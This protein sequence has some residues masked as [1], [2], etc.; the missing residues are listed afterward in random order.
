MDTN[1][2]NIHPTISNNKQEQENHPLHIKKK[3]SSADNRQIHPITNIAQNQFNRMSDEIE[4]LTNEEIDLSFKSKSSKT[5]AIRVINPDT[6]HTEKKVKRSR[7]L[8]NVRSNN[9][10]TND[11]NLDAHNR[12]R[13][14][15]ALKSSVSDSKKKKQKDLDNSSSKKP[16]S[17]SRSKSYNQFFDD[18]LEELAKKAKKIKKAKIKKTRHSK[19]SRNLEVKDK[20]I[21][22]LTE[23]F[24]NLIINDQ[25]TKKAKSKRKN[26]SLKRSNSQLY[27]ENR[28]LDQKPE[29]FNRKRYNQKTTRN[30]NHIDNYGFDD[31][32]TLKT[33]WQ[34]K[35]CILTTGSRNYK[36]EIFD[37]DDKELHCLKY[38]RKKGTILSAAL[39]VF[40]FDSGKKL[41]SRYIENKSIKDM[42][43]FRSTLQKNA[44]PFLNLPVRTINLLSEYINQYGSA[45][46]TTKK[47]IKPYPVF[48]DEI[49]DE[50]VYI[51][52][53][54]DGKGKI[55]KR[56][57]LEKI[58]Q[59]TKALFHS[60]EDSE[61]IVKVNNFSRFDET[62]E[63]SS[64]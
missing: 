11:V 45:L 57:A 3:S 63:T 16:K 12:K 42:L 21:D 51:R 52:D 28:Y 6:A 59:P 7:T 2:Y 25:S 64:N 27:L 20:D 18:K 24:R 22:D 4:L 10:K 41:R 53:V 48:V 46:I 56:E 61:S 50:S 19:S 44:I 13:T 54:F 31:E 23:Q 58:W 29:F 47:A 9:N 34:N 17:R 14:Q 32:D 33:I 43:V 40:I 5:P 30:T 39:E 37:R 60:D 36:I 55:I 38:N 35:L 26:K 8:L 49:T 62:S 15:E 1:I